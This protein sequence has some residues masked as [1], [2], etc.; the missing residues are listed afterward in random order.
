[1][2]TNRVLDLINK[3]TPA[4][5]KLMHF[6][7]GSVLTTIGVIL[8]YLTGYMFFVYTPALLAGALKEIFDAEPDMMDFLYTVTPAVLLIILIFTQL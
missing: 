5:D 4:P 3:I 1:M 8:Y 7:W 2:E 6:F